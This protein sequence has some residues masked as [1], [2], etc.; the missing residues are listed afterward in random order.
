MKLRILV[1]FPW[2][3]PFETAQDIAETIERHIDDNYGHG[4]T[5]GTTEKPVLVHMSLDG[6]PSEFDG[7]SANAVELA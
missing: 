2:G 3:T 1:D 6:V 4:R 7:L 5:S